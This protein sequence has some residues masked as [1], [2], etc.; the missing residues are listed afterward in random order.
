MKCCIFSSVQCSLRKLR[1]ARKFL[2]TRKLLTVECCEI[3]A[4]MKQ[5]DII[6]AQMGL[7]E[8]DSPEDEQEEIAPAKIERWQI[9][10]PAEYCFREHLSLGCEGC[11]EIPPLVDCEIW[12]YM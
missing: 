10:I 7:K 1:N 4:V 2:K 12:S 8:S 6:T 5:E 11:L 9:T 3:R